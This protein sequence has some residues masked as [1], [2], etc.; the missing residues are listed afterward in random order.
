MWSS[1]IEL[2][3]RSLGTPSRRAPGVSVLLKGKL[4]SSAAEEKRRRDERERG[5]VVK[6]VRTACALMMLALVAGCGGG[7]NEI[8]FL[9]HLFVTN[10]KDGVTPSSGN[11]QSVREYQVDPATGNL[12]L[13]LATFGT[14]AA[15]PG[16]KPRD[17][18]LISFGPLAQG[19]LYTAYEGL[20][21]NADVDQ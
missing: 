7:G 8:N 21:G 20:P 12:T 14:T 19:F 1:R 4:K 2:D 13:L 5:I 6:R 10:G 16:S 17:L 3:A 15:S 9:E 18:A 11:A